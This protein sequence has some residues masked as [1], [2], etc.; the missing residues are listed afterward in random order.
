MEETVRRMKK[1]PSVCY[2]TIFNEGWGQFCAAEQYRRLKKL[3]RSRFIDTTSGWFE[4]RESDVMSLHVYFKPVKIGKSDKPIVLSEFGGY[5]YKPAGHVFNTEKTYG[6]RFF[7]D[8]DEFTDALEKLYRDEIIPAKDVYKRQ[9][10]GGR[11]DT[12]FHELP[13]RNTHIRLD[14]GAQILRCGGIRPVSYTHL[15]TSRGG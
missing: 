2:Y 7:D 10:R 13:L 9:A 11:F 14:A 15:K 3:D 1:H 6:Y 8:R 5:S 4:C 12:V